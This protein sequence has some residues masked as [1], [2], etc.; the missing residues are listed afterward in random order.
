M[1]QRG[2]KSVAN[3]LT[4]RV[5]GQP[6]RLQAPT[7][8]NRTERKQFSD[9]VNAC[10]PKH[11]AESDLPLLTTYVQS[12]VMARRAIRDPK[13]IH[14]WE[15]AT[16]VQAMLATKLRLAPQARATARSITRNIPPRMVS[17]PLPWDESA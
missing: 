17:G 6:S 12:C 10:S 13:K 15:K 11:F 16:R 4:M 9:L 1:R 8:L 7:W 5:D 2:R 14:V 3:M